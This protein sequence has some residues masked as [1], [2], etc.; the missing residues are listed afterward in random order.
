M[1]TDRSLLPCLTTSCLWYLDDAWAGLQLVL[2]VFQDFDGTVADDASSQ[3]HLRE[4][5]MCVS[6]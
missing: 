5:D 4:T 3:K 6:L 1:Q 2:W